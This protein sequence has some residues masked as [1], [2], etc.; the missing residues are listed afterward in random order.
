VDL[1]SKFDRFREVWGWDTEFRPDAN[2][3]PDLVTLFAKEIR[4]ERTTRMRLADLIAAGRL[5]FGNEPDTLVESYSAVAELACCLT[6]GVPLPANVLCT[7]AET[8]AL[9]NGLDIDGL[10]E[11]RPSLLEACDLFGIEHMDKER[12]DAVRDL[13]L[14]KVPSEYTSTEWTLIEDYNAEDVET[15]IKLFMAEVTAID[16]PAALFRG[17]YSKAV[18]CME[19]IG[20]PVDAPYVNELSAVWRDLRLHYIRERDFLRLYDDD[21]HFCEDRMAA[22]IE[23]REWFWPRTPK[24]GRYALDAKTFGQMVAKHPELK[25]IQQ[26]RDQIAELRLGAFVNTIGADGYSRCPIMPWWTRTGRNQPS[27]KGL[28]YLLSLPAWVHGVIC[29][30]EGYG[31]ACLDWVAQE[32]GLGA[33]LSG[34]PAMIADFQSGDP[35]LGLAIRTGLAPEGA[36]KASHGAIRKTIKPVSLGIPY[37]ITEYGVARQT[38][39]SRRWSREVLAA[40]RHKYRVYFEW[41]TGVVTQAVFDRRIV[42]PLGFPMAVH[43]NTP[44]RTLK[45]YL[46]QAGGADMLR[47]SAVTGAAA[48]VVAIAPVHD[49]LWIM[50]PIR[51]LDDAIATMSRLMVRASAVVTGGLEI[52]VEVSAKVCWPNCLG[53]VRHDDDKGQALWLEI[54]GLVRDILRRRAV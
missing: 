54:K 21:G 14:E 13:I 44:Q 39:K 42:S 38:G 43:Q 23:A 20:M 9:I 19:N 37:G 31:I 47:L 49:S 17:Q 4:S 34:C 41:Q 15:D 33:G 24:S 8:S 50:A 29:P 45:N 26:L 11:K 51:E 22:L 28:A 30:P 46:H 32:F 40:V 35:H 10:T 18:A 3:R 52:P 53:D 12:K 7:Y 48:G 36:T 16:L 2:H 1:P 25:Q 27:G 5:P 6:A